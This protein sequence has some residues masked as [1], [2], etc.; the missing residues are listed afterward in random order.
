MKVSQRSKLKVYPL[1][2]S[3]WKDLEE[4]FGEKGAIGGCWCTWWRQRQ[5]EYEKNKGE[6]NK[7]ILHGLAGEKPSPGLL[8]YDAG[9]P[10]AWCSVSPRELYP[11]LEGSRILKPIDEQ[12][13]WSVVCFF[14]HRDYRSKGVSIEILKA[15]IE[16]SK[17]Q[18][19]RILE[20]YP[21][22]TLGGKTAALFIYTGT[23]SAFKKAGFK[24]VARRS[25]KRPI[26][27]YTLK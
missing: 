26:M 7:K 5:S 3:R 14:I 19:A 2:K 24:E 18:G 23:A 8:A 4:L 16:Y 25:D 11:R 9:K 6:L 12:E 13:V 15:A 22:D 21:V 20:G 10:I 1:S 17:E 27:R